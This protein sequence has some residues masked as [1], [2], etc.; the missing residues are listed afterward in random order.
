VLASEK[1]TSARRIRFGANEHFL[2]STLRQNKRI[3]AQTNLPL[4][5]DLNPDVVRAIDRNTTQESPLEFLQT[6]ITQ[7]PELV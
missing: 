4:V 1:P 6:P 5:F 7:L 3:L 2:F